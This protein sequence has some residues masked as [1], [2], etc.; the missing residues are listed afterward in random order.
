MKNLAT[1]FE[2]PVLDM[3]RAIQFYSEV[4]EVAFTKGV[5]HECEMAFF[6]QDQGEGISGALAKGSVYRPSV[7]GC[8]IYLVTH[9]ID[10]TLSKVNQL[11]YSTLFPKTEVKGL[12]YSAEFKDCEGNRIA[13]FQGL[14]SEY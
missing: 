5:I 8:L 10:K 3:E 12:G 7:N 11:G 1:Y 13:L 14:D 2:I 6:P 9:D 4:F